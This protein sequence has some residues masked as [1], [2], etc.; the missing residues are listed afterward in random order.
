LSANSKTN[1]ASSLSFE[2]YKSLDRVQHTTSHSFL[3]NKNQIKKSNAFVYSTFCPYTTK[4]MGNDNGDH[5]LISA[6][7]NTQPIQAE[8][9]PV[10]KKFTLGS[11]LECY[12]VGD[13]HA[14]ASIIYIYDIFA[15][16]PNAY[17]GC[18]I[19]ANSGFRVIMPDWFRGDVVT[20]E[21]L[22]DKDRFTQFIQTKGNYAVMEK[23]INAVKDY[24]MEKE[25]FSSIFSIGFCW[26]AKIV[27]NIADKN[28]FIK[29][30][31]LVHPSLL[32]HS[33]FVNCKVPIILLPSM[34]E[35]DMA[36]E[37]ETLKAKPFGHKCFHQRFEDMTHGWCAA[38]GEW[39]NPLVA[40]R[41]N[42]AFTIV[43]KNFKAL[44]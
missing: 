23:D 11:D 7:C 17:Q 24:L 14:K 3:T 15:K 40:A 34:N 21:M 19:L 30:G 43:V 31:A 8:Y 25:G 37:Y 29:G 44:I 18:D 6:C 4:K 42:E 2:N 5:P 12:I 28:P 41:A 36:P 33:D 27:M 38:R 22:Q 9:T 16:H 13:K 1:K 20:M 10:G 32:E 35:Y 39:N 26:G